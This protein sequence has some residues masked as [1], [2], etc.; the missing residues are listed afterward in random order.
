MHT[1]LSAVQKDSVVA[2]LKLLATLYVSYDIKLSSEQIRRLNM[3]HRDAAIFTKRFKITKAVDAAIRTLASGKDPR[4]NDAADQIVTEVFY[5]IDDVKAELA[6]E[7]DISKSQLSLIS[8]FRL[9]HLKG[10]E[11]AAKRLLRGVSGIGDPQVTKFFT[12]DVSEVDTDGVYK[13]LAALVKKEGGV[14]GY[15]MPT[16]ILEEWQAYNKS[17]TTKKP[18]HTKYLALRREVN[19]IFKKALANMV[20]GSGE[21]YLP[22]RDVIANLKAQGIVHN[23]PSGFVGNIDDLGK[24]YT[25]TGKQLLQAPSGDVRMNPKY[26]PEEDNA[27]VCEFT[28]PFAQKA[29]RGYTVTYRT[30]A[31]AAKFDV[32][33]E[34][35]PKLAQ[36]TKK[37]IPD[38]RLVN[39]KKEGTLATLCEFVYDSSARVGN[40]NAATAGVR[41]YGATQLLVKHFKFLTNGCTVTYVGKSGG[42]QI[43]KLKFDSVRGRQLGEALR[44]FAEGKGPNDPMFTFNG[45]MVT[46]AMINRYMRELGFP[47]SFTIHK[48]RTA[49]GTEMAMTL[50]KNSPFKKGDGTKETVVHKW[51]ETELLKIGAELGHMSGEKVT[52]NTAIQNYISPELLA[53]FY[54]KLGMR[55]SSKV[56][57][58][59]D[60]AKK[61]VV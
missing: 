9:A 4:T 28:P 49:R 12:H 52:A 11:S 38:L 31:K 61:E 29:T 43:H 50:L 1:S 36:L 14:S 16:E 21:P 33:A 53:E 23:L 47:T 57:K 54:S 56:Q 3:W 59:I 19:D 20:R 34:V 44:K 39:K 15:I 24:F 60:S 46:G 5:Q 27:Y 17:H 37:W 40:K 30:G 42:K 26:N 22:L 58:A 51:L 2:F 8:D 18:A 10:S 35:L 55:P 45:E 48:L 25:T 6:K 41:T 7:T 32:V 13:Q